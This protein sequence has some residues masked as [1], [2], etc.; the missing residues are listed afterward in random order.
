MG[1]PD[2]AT[3]QYMKNIQADMQ[4]EQLN[5]LNLPTLPIDVFIN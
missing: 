3:K 5:N 2:A 1:D 4:D